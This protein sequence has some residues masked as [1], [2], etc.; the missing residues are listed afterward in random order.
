M[1]NWRN[2]NGNGDDNDEKKKR[3]QNSNRTGFRKLDNEP[4]I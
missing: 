3:T 1:F 4:F 2:K